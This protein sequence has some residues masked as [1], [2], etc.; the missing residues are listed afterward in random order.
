MRPPD[1]IWLYSLEDSQYRSWR[2]LD[3]GSIDRFAD[4][5]WL[6]Q[7]PEGWRE[8]QIAFGTSVKYFSCN[9]SVSVPLKFVNEGAD[10]IRHILYKGN[11]YEEEVFIAIRKWNRET[12]IYELEYRGRLDFTQYDDQPTVGFTVNAIEGGVWTYLAANDNTTY[13]IACDE[14][15][16]DIIKVKFDGIELKDKYNFSFVPIDLDSRVISLPTVFLNNEGDSIGIKRGD[17]TYE[18]VPDANA[19]VADSENSNYIFSSLHPTSI[20]ITGSI[21]FDFKDS[22]TDHGTGHISASLILKTKNQQIFLIGDNIGIG[23]GHS[24]IIAGKVYTYDITINLVAN[25]P[26]FILYAT[27]DVLSVAK[28]LESNFS[29]EFNT[30]N[31]ESTTFALRPLDLWKRLV[32]A[33]TEG[34]YT[35]DSAFLATHNNIVTAGGEA[36]RNINRTLVPN[37]KIKTSVTDFYQSYNAIYNLG[38]KVVDNVLYIEPKED[39]YKD[40]AE[41]FDLGEVSELKIVPPND[42]LV[43]SLKTG[44]PIQNYQE[45]NGKYEFNSTHEYKLPVNTIQK[46]LNLVSKYRGDAYGIEFIRG[47]LN[48]KDTTDNQG[49]NEV[50]LINIS[51]SKDGDGNY[52]LKRGPYSIGASTLSGVIT[53]TIYNAE[54]MTP[55]NQLI[56]HGN[57]L[58]GLL[59]QLGNR[60]ITLQT[61][62]KNKE[63]SRTTAGVT[64][65]EKANLLV[66][67]LAKPLFYPYMFQFKGVT[68]YLFN[69][70][71]SLLGRGH[72]RF[73]FNGHELFGLPIGN[74]V[75]KPATDEPQEWKILASPLNSLSTLL[76]LSSQGLFISTLNQNTMWISDL[77]PL[78]FVRYGFNLPAKHHHADIF[79]D[80]L[81]NRFERF[82]EKAEYLQKWQNSDVIKLQIITA[83]LTNMNVRIYNSSAKQVGAPLNFNVVPDA[84]VQVPY[85]KQQLDIDLNDFDDD[86]YMVV[87]FTD[88]TPIAISEWFAVAEEWSETYSFE[89]Y[90]TF[91]KQDAYFDA[92]RPALRVE[93][94]FGKWM[95]DSSFSNYEDEP[96]NIEL[97]NSIPS[98][99]RPLYLGD[100]KGLPDWLVLKLNHILLLN[101]VFIEGERYTR[102]P[103]SKLDPLSEV[104]GYAMSAYKVDVKKALNNTGLSIDDT[105]VTQGSNISSF[106]L[107]AESYGRAPGV[108]TVELVN[109]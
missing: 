54:E 17:Q 27:A 90:N 2:V 24:Y 91:N 61:A 76:K 58:R 64:I 10:I 25:E 18:F 47:V 53:D 43:N 86:R 8:L 100:A 80:Y 21:V 96:G 23:E 70:T 107:D 36:I 38:L 62:D 4:P 68:P 55:T 3:N 74:M 69:K 79:D 12:G 30:K 37:Y 33:M 73:T 93:A 5:V 101:R 99:K 1:K 98:S 15:N 97:L 32:L 66:N 22:I 41:I 50:F 9:R 34:K 44:Y 13:E 102:L 109:E 26:L 19:Y 31:D 56:A 52:L 29:F 84:A 105:N 77:N 40:D 72:I 45:R 83:G 28:I 57:Y 71:L 60:L 11:G 104:N 14:T 94:L 87:I 95:P 49:D 92:W 35:G 108:I 67:N 48:N 51:N 7:D 46:E 6:K 39:L 85:V 42:Y 88:N 103:D 82:T 106:M 65:S 16:P 89:Y 78:H 63:L 20:R 81:I 75:A 59:Y